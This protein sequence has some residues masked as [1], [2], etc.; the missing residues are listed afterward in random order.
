MHEYRIK[1]LSSGHPIVVI[2]AAH[3]SDHDAVKSAKD[4]ADDKQ[5]EVWRGLDCIY[6]PPK[7][8]L[9]PVTASVVAA[10]GAWMKRILQA[11]S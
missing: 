5:F 1:V 7:P 8:H 2:D 9:A 10:A 6:A 4:L 11:S 3:V